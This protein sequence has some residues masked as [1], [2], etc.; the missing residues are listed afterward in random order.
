MPTTLGSNFLLPLIF[1]QQTEIPPYFYIDLLHIEVVSILL[2][3]LEPRSIEI[4]HA[5]ITNNHKRYLAA[6]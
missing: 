4:K 3:N 2:V 5:D 1:M 6:L